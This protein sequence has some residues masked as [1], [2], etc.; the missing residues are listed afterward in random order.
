MS[1]VSDIQKDRAKIWYFQFF[2]LKLN[3]IDNRVEVSKSSI[4]AIKNKLYILESLLTTKL[5]KPQKPPQ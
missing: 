1:H 4:Q 3:D 5:T 2:H